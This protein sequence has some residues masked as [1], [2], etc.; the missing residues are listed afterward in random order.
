VSDWSSRI[1]GQFNLNLPA[2]VVAWFDGELW[3]ES[4]E[5]GFFQPVDPE[6]L[7]EANSSTIMGGLMLPDTLPIL[8]N[9]CGDVLCLRFNS[10]GTVSEV[11]RWMHEGCD[12]TPYGN[13]LCEALL[14]DAAIAHTEELSA[15]SEYRLEE[16]GFAG[17]ALDHLESTGHLSNIR[18]LLSNE[19]VPAIVG[20]LEAGVAE[21]AVRCVLS[22]RCL[23]SE[24]LRY[25]RAAGGNQLAKKLRVGWPVFSQWL[26]D[27]ELVPEKKKRKLAKVTRVSIN[28]L[29]QQDW[30]GAVRE[31]EAVAALRT[32][33]TWPFAVLG[34]AAERQG[35]P[36]TAVKHYVAGLTALGTSSDFTENWGWG[37][38]EPTQKTKF[39]VE[40]L[41][42]LRDALPPEVLEN[43][44][45]KTALESKH[46]ADFFGRVREHWC[47]WAALAEKEGQFADAY[48]YYYCAGWDIHVFDDMESILDCMERNAEAAG[49]PALA[50]IASRHRKRSL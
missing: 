31:A 21:T 14:L 44:Y 17:W 28:E 18:Q 39:V 23:T 8:G 7:L 43:D 13:S 45:L 42:E 3:K 50:S 33:L 41:K 1:S 9:G 37:T 32:D 40:R 11:V 34:W 5:M 24:L 19:H 49:W 26:F 16:I 47:Q 46:S 38:F 36:T 22:Q 30:R 2:D 48:K 12:W 15:D 25:C 35:D 10:R 4:T 20:L 6:S 29:L 27:T